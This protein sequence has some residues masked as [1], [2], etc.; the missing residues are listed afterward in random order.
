MYEARM[1]GWWMA[2]CVEEGGRCFLVA[3]GWVL[4]FACGGGS[5]LGGV[6]VR[7]WLLMVS[8]F[9][10]PVLL[11]FR[12]TYNHQH[13]QITSWLVGSWLRLATSSYEPME[14]DLPYWGMVAC[15]TR[16]FARGGG[17][18]VKTVY[19]YKSLFRSQP[20]A[21]VNSSAQSN[22]SRNQRVAVAVDR[23]SG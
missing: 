11:N 12:H 4:R 20:T 23:H 19:I 18:R 8:K 21:V 2:G 15:A 7:G 22:Q 1:C 14:R 16:K 5:S 17:S 10:K 9:S 13:R 6:V 3:P